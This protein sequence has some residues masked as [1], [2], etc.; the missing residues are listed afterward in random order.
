M[1]SA[2]S[3]S[4][5]CH[6]GSLPF[7]NLLVKIMTI[8]VLMQVSKPLIANDFSL[9]NSQVFSCAKKG[10]RCATA[11]GPYAVDLAALSVSCQ[12]WCLQQWHMGFAIHTSS[13]QNPCDSRL[14]EIAGN[15]VE[16]FLLMN[17]VSSCRSLCA[18]LSFPL[19]VPMFLDNSW[20]KLPVLISPA[21]ASIFLNL[22]T[23]DILGLWSWKPSLSC[24]KI[25]GAWCF[26]WSRFQCYKDF[27]T[28]NAECES[29][30]KILWTLNQDFLLEEA[31]C[32][33]LTWYLE[34]LQTSKWYSSMAGICSG[35]P[36]WV[37][38]VYVSM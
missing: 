17:Q 26:V 7:I 1:Q 19:R 16:G 14:S 5:T 33:C 23:W 18:F 31:H 15:H 29:W 6:T 3:P 37:Y 36:D 28:P 22:E 21:V 10:P 38:M 30:L 4:R 34:L 12:M 11:I 24:F 32:W 2:I 13:I 35:F 9:E 25:Q 27:W 20:K 8:F